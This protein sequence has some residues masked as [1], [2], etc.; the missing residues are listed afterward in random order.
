MKWFF[1][2]GVISSATIFMHSYFFMISAPDSNYF[3]KALTFIY[4]FTVPY[5]FK[6]PA[7]KISF[8]QPPVTK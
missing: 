4:F 8:S 7:P 1:Y 2:A 3:L 6:P 5:L